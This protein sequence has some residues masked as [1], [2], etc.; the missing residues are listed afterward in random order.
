MRPLQHQYGHKDV[1]RVD[2]LYS[3]QKVPVKVSKNMFTVVLV[4]IYKSNST[5]DS[6]LLF[7]IHPNLCGLNG[8]YDFDA[9]VTAAVCIYLLHRLN[10]TRF[11]EQ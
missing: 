5:R 3:F 8:G 7:Q 1:K 2:T 6:L 11:R 10:A 4:W 9:D